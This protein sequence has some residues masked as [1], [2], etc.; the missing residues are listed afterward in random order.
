MKVLISDNLHAHGVAIFEQA[1][2]IEVINRPGMPPEEFMEVV[3]DVDGLVIRSATKVTD[4][5][6]EVASRLKVVGR[7]GTGLDNVNIP[8]ATK[9]GIVV[10]NTPGG[11][12]VTTGEHAISMMLALARNIPQA[13]HSMREGRWEKKRFQGREV[14]NKTLGIIGLGRIGTVVAGRAQGLKMRILGYDPFVKKEMVTSC[15]VELVTLDEL[16]ARSDFI[17]LHTPKTKDTAHIISREAFRKMKRGVMLINCARGGLIDEEALKEALEEGIVAGA[18]LDVFEQEPPVGSPLLL[19][20]NV[21]CTPHLGASTE[22]AQENVAVAI[23]E[24]MVDYLLNGTV[25]NAVNAPSVSGEVL[26]Q[27]RPYLT[28]AEA[29]GAFQAQIAEGPIDSVNIEY[30]GEISKL[31]TTPLMHSIMKGLLY[32]VM[33][34]EVNYVNAP[35]IAKDRGI[36]LTETKVESAEDFTT[37]IRLTVRAAQKENILAGTIFGRYEPRLVRINA[38]RLEAV[39]E[40]HMLFIYNTD[41]PGVIGAIGTTIG[42]HKINIARMTVGQE[43][44]RGQ[45]IILLTTDTSV[46]PECLADVRALPHVASAHPLEL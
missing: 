3:Q 17:T 6:L 13:A 44:E 14:Y 31:D 39:P 40:G 21:V 32:P 36:H 43:K 5:V 26:N 46:T 12:T 1:P 29:L 2:N 34:D 27:L 20:G 18:A 7:A 11:N 9:R 42:N 41:R 4:K 16:F 35:A 25:K 33:R 15:G 45:N 8:E 23:A 30:I 22:E 10:M 37:L 38:F 19:M 28:L 24:Q